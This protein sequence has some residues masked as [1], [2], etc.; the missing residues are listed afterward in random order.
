MPDPTFFTPTK[1]SCGFSF[2]P[3]FGYELATR[4]RPN[5]KVEATVHMFGILV[6]F[7][8][9]IAVTFQDISRLFG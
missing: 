3:A 2:D 7:I 1:K 5:P 9:L 4:R 6:L 8:V